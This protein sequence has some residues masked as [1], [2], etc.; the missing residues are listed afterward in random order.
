[1]SSKSKPP[2]LRWADFNVAI[3]PR[4]N[5]IAVGAC[6]STVPSVTGVHQLAA[7]APPDHMDIPLAIARVHDAERQSVVR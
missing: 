1:M 2:W 7:L 5:C 3:G 6:R 4:L